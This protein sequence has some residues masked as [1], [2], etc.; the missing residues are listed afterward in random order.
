MK[1]IE[2]DPLGSYTLFEHG[3]DRRWIPDL[4][5]EGGTVEEGWA[6]WTPE[7]EVHRQGYLRRTREFLQELRLE[8]RARA[9]L[10]A[11]PA[12]APQSR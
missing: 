12:L 4:D 5:L 2:Y 1:Q 9:F 8:A 11:F 7:T 6:L 10:D 3:G